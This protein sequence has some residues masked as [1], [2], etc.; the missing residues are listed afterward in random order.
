MR[1]F[2]LAWGLACCACGSAGTWRQLPSLPDAEGFAGAFAGV[3]NGALIVAGGANF[4]EKKP[5]EGGKKVWYDTV[6]ALESPEGTWR[7]AGTLPRPLGYGVSATRDGVV[8]VGG[9]DAAGH[10]ADVFRLEWRDGKLATR[11]LPPLPVPLAN[12]CGAMLGN[13]LYVAGGQTRPDAA[14]ALGRVFAMDF[15]A[16]ELAWREVAPLPGAGRILPVAA[17]FGGAFWVVGGAALHAGPD[18]LPARTYLRD[19]FCLTP[20]MGWK[21]IAELPYPVVAAPTPAPADE[22][23]FCLLGGDDG[24]Q[25]SVAPTAHTGFVDAMLR[26]GA[27][28]DKWGKAG[29]LPAPRVTAPCVFWEGMWVVPSGEARPG[30]RSPEVWGWGPDSKE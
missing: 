1:Y 25:V 17:S 29:K 7:V 11:A 9:S 22:R 5:W 2:L 30:V 20:G 21:R 3:S 14:E 15:S 26:H 28:R 27:R 10:H 19:G 18:G 24:R 13:T 12:G 4:P 6:Y 16:S 8:C 23:G